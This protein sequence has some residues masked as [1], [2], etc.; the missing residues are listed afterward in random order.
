MNE[1]KQALNLA[2]RIAIQMDEYE[3]VHVDVFAHAVAFILKAE[4]GHHNYNTFI[5]SL[6]KHLYGN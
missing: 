3:N 6:N 2:A 5:E 1:E 4:Y